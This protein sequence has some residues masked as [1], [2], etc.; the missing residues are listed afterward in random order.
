MIEIETMD[1]EV[2]KEGKG[3]E[4]PEG[5]KEKEALVA[6]GGALKEEM[7]EKIF[8][9]CWG[10]HINC[11][12][13]CVQFASYHYKMLPL[14]IEKEYACKWKTRSARICLPESETKV[15]F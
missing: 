3:A 4:A 9:T 10:E 2:L 13:G 1:R 5:V 7:R 12:A 8:E 15:Y 14:G 11:N 6:E